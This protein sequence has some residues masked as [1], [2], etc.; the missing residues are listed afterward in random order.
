M[1]SDIIK[2]R[3]SSMKEEKYGVGTFHET[4]NGTLCEVL[5]KIGGE[6][7]KVRFLEDDT[8]IICGRNS[9]RLKCLVNPRNTKYGVGSVHKTNEGYN[10]RVLKTIDENYRLVKFMD[11]FGFELKVAHANIRN[12]EVSNPFHI[13]IHGVGYIGENRNV[14]NRSAYICWTQMLSRC[15]NDKFQNIQPTYRNVKVCE[16]WHNFSKFE[17]WYIDNYPHHIE[18]IKFELDKDILQT[19]CSHKLYSPETTI[20]LPKKLNTFISNKRL[21]NTSGFTGVSFYKNGK[22]WKA[23]IRLFEENKT[24]HLGYFSTPE[25]ASLV[26]QKA[27]VEQSEKAKQYLRDLNYLPEE[28]IQLVN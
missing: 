26:Y 12:G 27:R 16:E 13:T 6:K 3:D 20:F 9:L 11:R 21:N 2:Y 15:Y 10:I 4:Y 8:E 23:Q 17:K 7:R 28:I 1:I 14:T 24:K 19:D 5:E 22:R 18:N 25:E